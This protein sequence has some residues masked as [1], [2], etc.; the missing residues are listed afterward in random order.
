MKEQKIIMRE[1][2]EA[3]SIQTVTG[4]MSSNGHF[5]G[6]DESTA[7]YDGCTHQL[8][9]GCGEVIAKSNYFCKC[10]DKRSQEK[11]DAMSEEPWDGESPIYSDWLDKYIF[12]GDIESLL[13]DQAEGT[14]ME[15]LRLIH[16]VP[17]YLHQIDTDVWEDELRTE[18][19]SAEVPSAVD[20][21]LEK[22][23]E[24]IKNAGPVAWQAGNKRVKLPVAI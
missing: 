15:D 22:L 7:R 24:A 16:C 18:D 17:V 20:E 2:P 4:W 10:S 5:Y 6:N 1:S 19:D 11:F 8:C 21:A 13:D 12:D 23:N 14:A 9:H 3:A